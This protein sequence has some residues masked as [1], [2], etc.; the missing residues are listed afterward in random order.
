M[1]HASGGR[2]RETSNVGVEH[3]RVGSGKGEG[4]NVWVDHVW[5]AWEDKLV[6]VGMNSTWQVGLTRHF[7]IS[8]AER[9]A[10]DVEQRRERLCEV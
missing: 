2:K 6:Q 10:Y 9:F 3:V 7:V 8:N 1:Q 5:I 4:L